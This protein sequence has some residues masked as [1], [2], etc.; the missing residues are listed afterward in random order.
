MSFVNLDEMFY[1]QRKLIDKIKSDKPD[2]WE[3]K[4]SFE[5]ERIFRLCSFLI[6]EAVEL[7]QETQ[8]KHWK[9]KE[10]YKIDYENRKVEIADLWHVL[11]QLTMECGMSPEDIL[12]AFN[13]KHKENM[14]RQQR[15]Y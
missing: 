13:N 11:I 14:D 9:A 7:Q 4:E 15:R 8:W 1:T 10:N 6:H 5:G 3:K 2:F 12:S